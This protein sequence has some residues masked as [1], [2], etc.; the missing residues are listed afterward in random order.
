M[1]LVEKCREKRP[2]GKPTHRWDANIKRAIKEV[3]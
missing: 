3:L 2:L 1:V